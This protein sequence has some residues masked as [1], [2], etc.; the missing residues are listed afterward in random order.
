MILIKFHY[1]I[2]IDQAGEERAWEV[3]I[4]GEIGTA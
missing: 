1:R 2:I 4:S 3:G